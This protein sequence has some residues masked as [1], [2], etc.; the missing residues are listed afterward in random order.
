MIKDEHKVIALT[1]LASISIWI[2]DAVID[3]FIFHSG[4]FLNLLLF[5]LSFHEFYF[6]LLFVVSFIIFGVIISRVLYN[7][8][9]VEGE[10]RK[11]LKRVIDETA[12]TEAIIEESQQRKAEISALLEAS[13]AVL[14]NR[15]FKDSAS[16]IFKSSKD[17]IGAV[18]GYIALLS[19]DGTENEVIFLDPGGFPC[20]VDPTLP[21]PVRGLREVVYRTGKAVYDNDFSHS[22]WM[23]F[24]PEGHA[25]LAN[26]LFAPLVIKG[27]TVG[28]LGLGNKLGGF[29]GN[30]AQ[31]A[32]AFGELAAIALHNSRL[33]E[34]IQ[35]SR[36]E[37]ELKVEARTTEL[38][39][40][41]EALQAIENE[42]RQNYDLIQKANVLFEQVF[43][44][45]H[46]LIAYIDTE[47]NVIHVNR[48]FA[49]ADGR[50]PEFFVGKNYFD[51]YPNKENEAIFKKV[52]EKGEPYF[53]YADPFE[54]PE[55]PERGVTYRDW[56]VQPIKDTAGNIHGLVLSLIN[57]TEKIL[58][59][60]ETMR[61]AH[62][63]SLGE[64]AAGV[65][66]EINNP[67]NGIINYA[68]MLSNR[69][70]KGSIENDIAQRIIKEGDRIA[71]IVRSLL[72]FARKRE[73]GKD[74]ANIRGILFDTLLLTETQ[75]LK[76]SI[77]LK[78]NVPH[79][80][81]EI[82]ANPQQIQQVF[83]NIIN[84]ARYALNQK[85][86][87][88][89]ED[90]ILEISGETIM[91][92]SHPYLRITFYDHGTGIPANI[93]DKVVNPFFSTK[94]GGKGT[95]LGLSISHG[96]ISDHGGRLLIESIEEEFTRVIIDL[97]TWIRDKK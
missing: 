63:A 69:I 32:S 21:M 87:M 19:K 67:L 89:D 72:S 51:L 53:T 62:L 37:M 9:L 31:M 90:K 12:K 49:D 93:L 65:A 77:D 96:I 74:I 7:H 15:E 22:E 36:D 44:N 35:K 57:V 61:A 83:L 13:R 43:S 68:Q 6:R 78:V 48:T 27:K 82:I 42:L 84:N 79:D 56:S 86:S 71:N 23:K 52:L 92:D 39:K 30:D 50:S 29:T 73:K 20:S 60:A 64:L 75:M 34:A 3:A 38:I 18:A 97:P 58:L 16:S 85:Y 17:L 8:K 88:A 76:E 54:Y 46:V 5:D 59:Q 26:V 4:T 40:A 2:I 14:E 95:G 45:I 70:S 24:V 10:L 11:A 25:N 55:H 66:H 94:P 33:M 80:L 28:L 47:F 81:S 41:N 91:I 1:F